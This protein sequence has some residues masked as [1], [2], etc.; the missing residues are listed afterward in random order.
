MTNLKPTE[1]AAFP[2]VFYIPLVETFQFLHD[3]DSF[4]KVPDSESLQTD[5]IFMKNRTPN[6]KVIEYSAYEDL[7]K[8]Y[9]FQ[10]QRTLDAL[11]DQDRLE[12]LLNEVAGALEKYSQQVIFYPKGFSSTKGFVKIPDTYNTYVRGNDLAREALQK[13]REFK[14]ES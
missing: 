14:S 6:I 12:S 13:Y 2:R 10:Q 11:N 8:K 3:G 7:E 9:A 1:S 4:K 5:P